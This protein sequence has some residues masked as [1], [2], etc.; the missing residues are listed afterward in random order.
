MTPTT[1]QLHRCP[2]RCSRSVR[3]GRHACTR[4]WD[5]LPLG[6]RAAITASTHTV[7][8]AGRDRYRRAIE[9]A[10]DWWLANPAPHDPDAAIAGECEHCYSPLLWLTTGA[11]KRMP[12]DADPD[13]VKGNVVR[14]GPVAGVLGPDKAVAARAGGTTL[15]THHVVTCPHADRWRSKPR[16]GTAARGTARR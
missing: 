11:G 5:R 13:P 4:C 9:D 10:R 12:V 7:T 8:Q 14:H 2:G 3:R 6:L 1:T 15:Y 16:P